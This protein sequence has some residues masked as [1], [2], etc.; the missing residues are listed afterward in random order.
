MNTF[1]QAKHLK[2]CILSHWF[3]RMRLSPNGELNCSPEPLV[4]DLK[5]DR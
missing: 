5:S 2:M 1:T 3:Y 4:V